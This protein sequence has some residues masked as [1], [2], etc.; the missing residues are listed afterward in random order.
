MVTDVLSRSTP[1]ALLVP[2]DADTKPPR[3]IV[4]LLVC[5]NAANAPVRK[6]A[7]I[8]ILVIYH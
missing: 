7:N 6:N 5:A 8:T 3:D 4:P 2:V 1:K